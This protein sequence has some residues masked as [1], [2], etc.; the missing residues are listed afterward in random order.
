MQT[1][2]ADELAARVNFLTAHLPNLRV[3]LCGESNG[4]AIAED[5][6]QRLK[7]NPRV[8]AIET[9][10]P[11][12]HPSHEFARSLVIDD[13][14]RDQDSFTSGDW[15]RIIRANVE[16]AFGQYQG[17]EGNILLYIGAPGHVY[18][19][20]YPVVRDQM[21]AFLAANFPKSP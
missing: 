12:W 1:T 5:A 13:N 9:G 11:C 14:G 21:N 16:A 20:D 10:P 7:D 2:K 3:I 8:Y 18:S 4:A 15:V 6:V 19:W 17:S